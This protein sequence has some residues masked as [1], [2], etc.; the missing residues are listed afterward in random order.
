MA[1]E[2]DSVYA[3][4]ADNN[5]GPNASP[6]W[7]I[8]LLDADH[9]AGS[10]A[11]TVPFGDVS[12]DDIKPVIGI[13]STPVIDPSTNTMYLVGKTKENGTHARL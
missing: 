11:T 2:N 6:L 12:I 8:S 5:G 3:F 9:G 7:T 10:G 4:D 1:T 13:T